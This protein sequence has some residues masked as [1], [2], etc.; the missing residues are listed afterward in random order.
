MLKYKKEAVFDK[1]QSDKVLWFFFLLMYGLK[2]V[3]DRLHETKSQA[4]T[5]H[6]I[7]K[8]RLCG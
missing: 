4:L 7:I 8:A 1:K 3:T 5:L 6:L 2:N